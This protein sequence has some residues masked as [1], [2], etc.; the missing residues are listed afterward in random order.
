MNRNRNSL[1]ACLA[2]SSLAAAPSAQ[3]GTLSAERVE[4]VL[5][6]L[7]SDALGGRDTPSR[8]LEEA[9]QFLAWSFSRAGLSPG[10]SVGASP[11]WFHRYTLPG[12][13][14]DSGG[15]ELRLV[16]AAGDEVVLEPGTDF[17][18]W[19]AGRAFSVEGVPMTPEPEDADAD[20]AR[21]RRR[22]AAAAPT[23]VVTA[24]AHPAWR[25]ADGPRT[26]L[27]RRGRGGAAPT[28]LLRPGVTDGTETIAA[29]R[30]PA[31]VE[32]DV[33]LR[34][35]VGMLPGTDLA[36]E[37]VLVGAHY[38]HV[39][40]RPRADGSDGIYNGADDDATGTT[41]VLLLA[42]HFAAQ[43]ERTRRTL[44]FVCFSAEEKG[45]Q[46]SRA[47]AAEPPFALSR[48]AAMVNLEMLGRPEKEGPPFAWVTGKEL[49]DFATIAGPALGRAGVALTDF[50][51][52]SRLFSASDNLPFAQKGV[53]AH[54]ISAGTLHSDYHQPG[55]EPS[56]IDVPHMT[57]V[58]A[59][60][61]EVVAEFANRDQRPAYTP[62]AAQRLSG[63]DR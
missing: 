49:S 39:G 6:Y 51:M 4:E 50:E 19:D 43:T 59:G 17:R 41:A 48:V 10:S 29:L 36:E 9:A 1:L 26:T 20:P 5:G 42:E 33:P 11:D 14:V 31:P 61:A 28:I 25:T 34:N 44:V 16:T 37:I 7:A 54:S 60:L 56:R 3:T 62:E 57:A 13:Q 52:A 53:V 8:G 55:D 35:V 46:G 15:V 22:M 58:L 12:Q 21:V 47:F 18:L 63:T 23:F 2:A 27:R 38:D 32:V 30:V 40:I 24:P 45:L